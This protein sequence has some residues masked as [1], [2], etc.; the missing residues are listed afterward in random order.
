L[1]GGDAVA[2]ANASPDR[3]EWRTATGNALSKNEF[4]AAVA[5]CEGRAKSA[6]ENGSF[7]RCLA[8]YGLSR[9]R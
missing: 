2:P 1:A 8:D 6:N 7:E 5:A 3:R 9:I 4:A